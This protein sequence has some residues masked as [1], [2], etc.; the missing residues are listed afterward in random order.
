MA[1]G[2]GAVHTRRAQSKRPASDRLDRQSRQV[3]KDLRQIG[4]TAKAVAREKL[5]QLRDNASDYVEQGRKKKQQIEHGFEQY[6]R[7]SPL[8]SILIATGVG[9]LL[10]R[11]W[12][13]R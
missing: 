10:G 11:F 3:T 2:N 1:T 5:G 9:L 7:E 8:K 4:A 12:R 13:R 6:I